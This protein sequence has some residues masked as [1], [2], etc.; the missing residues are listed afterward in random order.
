MT[1]VY[2]VILCLGVI[3]GA[4]VRHLTRLGIEGQGD[5]RLL[6][7]LA[8]LIYVADLVLLS[9]HRREIL[10]PGTRLAGG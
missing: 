4:V 6:F 1:A 10:L 5:G 2:G 7:G 3:A 8:V 9:P